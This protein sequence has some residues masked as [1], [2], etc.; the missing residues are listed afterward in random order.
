MAKNITDLQKNGVSA[1]SIGTPRLNKKDHSST[2]RSVGR[3]AQFLQNIWPISE[4]KAVDADDQNLA[5]SGQKQ[6]SF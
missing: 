6:F 2:F 3:T 5:R 1:T 4:Y